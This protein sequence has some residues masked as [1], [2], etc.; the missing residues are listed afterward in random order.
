MSRI[1]S[2]GVFIILWIATSFISCSDDKE[3]ESGIS[4]QSWTEG[5]TLDISVLEPLSVTFNAKDKWTASS[6]ESWC[7][8]TQ[9][10]NAGESTLEL[11][12]STATNVA[13]TTTITINVIG[14]AP[15]SFAVTQRPGD[16][17]A[18]DV[19]LN[20]K[21]DTY[22]KDMY[23]WNDEYK[24]LTLKFDQDYENFFYGALKSMKT[25]TL[26]KRENSLFSYIEKRATINSRSTKY[27]KKELR[28][29]FG[30][31]GIILENITGIGHCFIVQGVYPGSSSELAGIKRGTIITSVNGQKIVKSNY[32]NLYYDLYLPTSA[33]TME[34]TDYKNNK[35]II[36]SKAIYANPVIKRQVKEVNG[37]KIG[38]LV[39]VEFDAGYD[40]EL[41]KAF[42]YFKSK[43]VTDLILDLR[44]N[45]GG[46]VISANLITSC[47]AG[48]ASQ[49]KVFVQYRYNEERMKMLNNKRP[50]EMFAY[51]NYSNLGTSLEAG[52]LNLPRV[53]C[54]VGNGTAS[55]SELVINS[56]RGID[57]EVVLIGE[58]TT[59][60]NVGMEY[61]DFT[62]GDDLYRVVP[63]T[64]Q[65]YNAKGF[66]DYADGFTPDVV[67]DELNPQ[68]EDNKIYIYKEFGTDKEYLYAAAVNMITGKNPMPN[69]R[70]IAGTTRSKTRTLP[71]IFKPGQGGM[72]KSY[73]K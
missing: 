29:D 41:L 30:I 32:I 3:L 51:S 48:S 35:R 9:A 49:G 27:I 18:G 39:Y 8:P 7:E 59:G 67:I 31:T 58:K 72:L 40:D 11:L 24:G 5:K 63:I 19:E 64:F 13:R 54:L 6:S 12:A 61:E 42:S 21:V 28:Y 2:V 44:Y 36:T 50:Q 46:H 26:D 70:S 71:Q 16:A 4:G 66:G 60:K 33:K 20:R 68:N 43:N 22:L 47:I 10:G 56:L 34:V 73:E 65:T 14:Y 45:R 1:Y 37:R 53:Y 25:N 17:T 69:T 15:V 55:A 62:V 52:G 38:Y 57:V 23:L